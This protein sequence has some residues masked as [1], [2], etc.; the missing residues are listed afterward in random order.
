M[1]VLS[2]SRGTARV[3]AFSLNIIFAK[4]PL[5]LPL[6]HRAR[7]LFFPVTYHYCT[8]VVCVHI[9]HLSLSLS[10]PSL[11]LLPSVLARL[12]PMMPTVWNDRFTDE[13]E[14]RPAPSSAEN[15]HLNFLPL[16]DH[17]LWIN[18][19][20]SRTCA[21]LVFDSYIKKNNGPTEWRFELWISFIL[22]NKHQP[23]HQVIKLLWGN[24]SGW[25]QRNCIILGMYF[26]FSGLN[27]TN[28]V[29]GKKL[30]HH[31]GSLLPPEGLND[32]PRE[33]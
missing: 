3:L 15:V 33:I 22:V 11:W 27:T 16:P 21:G 32:P 5:S 14:R 8:L 28:T 24:D 26:T 7:A 23:S 30:R 6:Q 18:T 29:R 1:C 9:P 2:G 25:E 4:P 31:S 12:Q 20:G 19:H 17:Q 13:L 10:V